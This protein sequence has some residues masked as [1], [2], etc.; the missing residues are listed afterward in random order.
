LLIGWAV[1]TYAGTAMAVS[2]KLTTT[3]PLHVGAYTFPGYT[4]VYTVLLNLAVV[5]VLTLI[6]NAIGSRRAPVDETADADY[7]A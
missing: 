2:T 6:F 7:F 3:F 1:G 4:A 5:I